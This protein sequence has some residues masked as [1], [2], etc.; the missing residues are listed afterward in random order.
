MKAIVFDT[1]TTSLAAASVADLKNQ[2]HIIEI[3]AGKLELK[4]DGWQLIDEID[5][6]VNPPIPIDEEITKITNITQEMVKGKPSIGAVF[7]KI[8]EFFLETDIVVAHNLSYDQFVMECESR[9]LG[10]PLFTMPPTK[11]CTVESSEALLGR[12]MKLVDLHEHLFGVKFEDAHRA[13]HDVEATIKCF[14][15]LWM[16]GEI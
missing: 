9:R 15:K 1:E 6:M 14:N 10:L 11:I 16:D 5:I 8:Q 2:P 3:Y 13:R 12:R 7:P 4:V